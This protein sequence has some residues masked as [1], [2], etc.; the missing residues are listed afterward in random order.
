VVTH[1]NSTLPVL[2]IAGLALLGVL[3]AAGF[4]ASR[5]S[6]QRNAMA[7]YKVVTADSPLPVFVPI[8]APA[9]AMPE[10]VRYAWTPKAATAAAPAISDENP[11]PTGA[12]REEL[13]ARMVAAEPD[14]ANP[15]TSGKARRRRARIILQSREHRQQEAAAMAPNASFTASAPSLARTVT[16]RERTPA[17]D[18]AFA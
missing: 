1:D 17:P 7:Q 9:R 11:V 12:E 2:P 18:F 14:A 8:P 15:F 3:G 13:L 10:Q 16:A 5:R 4:A 6:R